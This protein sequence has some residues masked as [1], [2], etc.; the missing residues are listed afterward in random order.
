VVFTGHI[1]DMP[2]AYAAL[3]I[4][5]SASINPEPLGTVVIE[6]M[7]MGRPLVA[8]NH[9]GGAEMN[10]HDETALLFEPGSAESLADCILRIYQSPELGQRL[11]MAARQRALSTFDV[12]SHVDRVQEVY[13]S[14]LDS[15]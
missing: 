7:A 11:G 13:E 5:V 12:G 9:G 3:D 10:T 14:L 15:G 6:A 1:G 4:V 2:T 8:P